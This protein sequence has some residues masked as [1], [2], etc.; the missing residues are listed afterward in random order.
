MFCRVVGKWDWSQCSWLRSL[1]AAVSS[2]WV[3]GSGSAPMAGFSLEV[4]FSSWSCPL[5]VASWGLLWISAYLVGKW[6]GRVCKGVLKKASSAS[7]VNGV[8]KLTPASIKS[9]MPY[10]HTALSVLGFWVTEC[11]WRC[12]EE[13]VSYSPPSLLQLSLIDF[14]SSTS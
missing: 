2:V 4:A 11:A 7:K 8:L 12:R 1:A 5:N 13:S 14:Q 6:V 9:T 3:V 10:S